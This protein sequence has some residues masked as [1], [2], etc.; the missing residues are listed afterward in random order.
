MWIF[1]LKSLSSLHCSNAGISTRTNGL[2]TSATVMWCNN[3]FGEKSKN[4]YHSVQASDRLIENLRLLGALLYISMGL[5]HLERSRNLQKSCKRFNLW[6][7]TCWI[8]ENYRLVFFFRFFW[9]SNWGCLS[10]WVVFWMFNKWYFREEYSERI[11][12]WVE[13][14]M[15]S[16]IIR[17]YFQTR[18]ILKDVLQIQC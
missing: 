5:V 2:S 17:A 16:R 13:P 4:L 1:V 10:N 14:M 9:P 7:C 18:A 3:Q 6:L 11:T 15:S 12:R 8:H